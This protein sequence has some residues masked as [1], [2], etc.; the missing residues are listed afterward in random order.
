MRSLLIL[1]L[2]PVAT[3]CHA[4]WDDNKGTR[5]EAS[6]T[7]ASRAFAAN[8]FTGIALKSSD[9][10]DVRT[11]AAFSVQAEGDPK[12]L[13]QLDIRLDGKTLNV[14]RKTR[15]GMMWDKSGGA[16]IH[17]VMPRLTDATVGGS[18]T[19]RVDRVEGKFGG[20]VAGSGNLDIAAAAADEASLTIAGSG[21][22]AVAGRADKLDV[23]VAGSGDLRGQQFRAA[24]ADI[25]IA[26]SGSVRANVSGPASISILGSGDVELHGGAQCKV[27]K[28]GSG[29]AKCS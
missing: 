28:I 12:V 14:G 17:I 19:L 9:D 10:I 22:I 18:G 20:V 11:G 5:I 29:E 7:G 16:K 1:A 8:G 3:A 27:S 24:R 4:S 13:D 6:G 25:S 23:S 21:D 2:L 26:G 15:V